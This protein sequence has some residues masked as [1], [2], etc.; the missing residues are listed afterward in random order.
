MAWHFNESEIKFSN[1]YLKKEEEESNI[2]K[3]KM[4]KL[5]ILSGSTINFQKYE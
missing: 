1:K 3:I 2:K 4:L 5:H